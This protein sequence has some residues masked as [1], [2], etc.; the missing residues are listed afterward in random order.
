[1]EMCF[2]VELKISQ[3]FFCMASH[4][5]ADKI[6]D[7]SSVFR[8]YTGTLQYVIELSSLII[9]EWAV[10]LTLGC[11]KNRT[12]QNI[13]FLEDWMDIFGE[14]TTALSKSGKSQLVNMLS[15]LNELSGRNSDTDQIPDEISEVSLL[16]E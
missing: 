6:S 11:I 5:S 10:S 13:E 9:N 12:N 2:N 7:V 16:P 8:A 3:Q 14:V 15:V 1:M 4:N